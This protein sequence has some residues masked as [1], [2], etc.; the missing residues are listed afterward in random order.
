MVQFSVFAKD[1]LSGEAAAGVGTREI[2]PGDSLDGAAEMAG[3]GGGCAAGGRGC[4]SGGISGVGET[5]QRD[6]L[7]DRGSAL[8]EM[9]PAVQEIFE[10]GLQ[11]RRRL[12]SRRDAL[13]A[14][15]R[16]GDGKRRPMRGGDWFMTS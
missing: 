16:R 12:M 6:D 7:A 10:E 9:L 15:H 3:G 5:E 1:N 2:L 14:I 4:F 8:P 13:R 11:K